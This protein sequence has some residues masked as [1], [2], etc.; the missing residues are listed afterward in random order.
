MT[1]EETVLRERLE[2]QL[3]FEMLLTEISTGFINIAPDQVDDAI[4]DAQRRVCESLDIDRSALWQ[5]FE[6][7]PGALLLT[8][9]HQPP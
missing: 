4:Q 8:H 2:A 3:R 5:F 7:E 1:K 6:R 9:I